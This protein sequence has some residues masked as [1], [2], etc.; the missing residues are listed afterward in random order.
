MTPE[1]RKGKSTEIKALA[2]KERLVNRYGAPWLIKGS[3]GVGAPLG[4][5]N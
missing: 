4:V 5:R 2:C 3:K 1:V